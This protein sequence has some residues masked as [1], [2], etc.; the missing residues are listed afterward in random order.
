MPLSNGTIA[1][2][3]TDSAQDIK[4]QFID[5]VNNGKYAL[6]LH[7]CTDVSNAVQLLVFVRYSFDGKL[8]E[9]MFCSP[10]EV[11]RTGEDIFKKTSIRA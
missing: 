11:T 3:I 7:K 9:D 8:H 5:R 10:L 1:R 2:R 4:C 6:Q